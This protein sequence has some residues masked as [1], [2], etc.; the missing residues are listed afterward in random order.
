MADVGG[1]C[2]QSEVVGRRRMCGLTSSSVVRKGRLRGDSA[3]RF[4]VADF[5]DSRR[6]CTGTKFQSRG[7]FTARLST[8]V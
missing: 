8:R 2:V 5:G 1:E 6:T 3:R 4:W 7:R